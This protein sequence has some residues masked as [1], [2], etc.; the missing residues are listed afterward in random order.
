MLHPERRLRRSVDSSNAPARPGGE[1]PNA[2]AHYYGL[3]PKGQV[4][5]TLPEFRERKQTHRKISMTTCY[6]AAFAAILRDTPVDCLLVGDSLAMVVYGERTT[7][8]A[9]ISMIAAHARAVRAG[10]P[11]KFL[12]ADMP[13]LSVRTGLSE[14]VNAAGELVRAGADAVKIEGIAGNEEAVRRLAESGIPVMGHLGLMPQFY[15]AQGGWKVQGR[16]G[17]GAARILSDA[18]AFQAAGAFALVLECVPEPL[19][20]RV[21]EAL[22]IPV[23]GIGAGRSVD[24]Q[25]L[26]LHD[27]LGLS[28]RSSTFARRYLDGA[29]LVGE[30]VSRYC[31]DIGS[32]AFPSETETFAS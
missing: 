13:F 15:H 27:L 8:P 9:T 12:I 32:G 18:E 30:A 21:A 7:I 26:V 23:I 6:D 29:A 2:A 3:D 5:M 1:S 11:K 31:A 28:G 14:A 24:G 20:A 16:D 17:D 4:L 19:A 10:A 22:D 25:V